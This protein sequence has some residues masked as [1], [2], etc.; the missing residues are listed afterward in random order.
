MLIT[1][2]QIKET[3]MEIFLL[4]LAILALIY[5]KVFRP[6]KKDSVKP[7]GGGSYEDEDGPGHTSPTFDHDDFR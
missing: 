1:K 2:S 3:A 5:F 6:D 7:S 4:L